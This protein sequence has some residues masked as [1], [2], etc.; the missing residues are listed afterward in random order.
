MTTPLYVEREP[1]WGQGESLKQPR[2]A[3]FWLFVVLFV[4]GL[5]LITSTFGGL[6]DASPDASMLAVVVWVAYAVPFVF[7]IVWLDLLEPEPVPFIAAAL[8]WGAVVATSLAYIGNTALLSIVFKIGGAHF[9]QD[10]GTAIAA[11]TNEEVLKALG[12]VVVILI[13]KRQ[14][15][16]V[17]DGIVYGAFVGLGFQVFEDLIYTLRGVNAAAQ[18]GASATE[19][20]WQYFLIRGLAGGLYSHAVYTAI[21]GAGIAYFVVRTDR[22]LQHRVAV[23]AALFAASWFMHFVWNSR[24]L[25]DQ[26]TGTAEYFGVA[27]IK[28]LPALVLLFLLYRFARKREVAWFDAALQGEDEWVTPE[29]VATLH[30]RS[31]RR[32][33]GKAERLRTGARGARMLRQLQ[34]SQVRFAVAIVRAGDHSA[35][36]V[37]EAR[38]DVNAARAALAE[39]PPVQQPRGSAAPSAASPRAGP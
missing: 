7:V 13:A 10:W 32:A 2:R 27:F 5:I 14:V 37:T 34:Q 19:Q 3:A 1:A 26:A 28:G 15:N 33:A 21:V 18:A 17:L 8:A 25:N 12:V 9:T 22:S 20:V 39:A 30:S 11:P 31:A 6:I 16:T 35:L 23:V 24:W 4:F 36:S 38:G 29:E